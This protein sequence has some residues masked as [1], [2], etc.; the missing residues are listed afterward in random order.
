MGQPLAALLVAALVYPSITTAQQ[1]GWMENQ[2]NA[3]MCF[4]EQLRGE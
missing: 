3:T 1:S 2:V 4:W